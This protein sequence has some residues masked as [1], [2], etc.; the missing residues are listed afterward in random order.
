MEDSI[1]SKSENLR[2]NL[3][4]LKTHY[5]QLEKEIDNYNNKVK[6]A[7]LSWEEDFIDNDN[8]N[9]YLKLDEFTKKEIF[10]LMNNYNE[11]NYEQSKKIYVDF[12]KK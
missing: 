1:L 4:K 10:N 11:S 12:G 5:N 9:T 2:I 3:E 8:K 6:D 7:V